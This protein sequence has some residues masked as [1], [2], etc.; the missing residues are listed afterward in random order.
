MSFYAPFV[1]QVLRDRAFYRQ[2]S[3][4]LSPL[5]LLEMNSN[6]T[7]SGLFVVKGRPLVGKCT[8]VRSSTNDAGH[9]RWHS[10]VFGLMGRRK[11]KSQNV[12]E[13]RKCHKSYTMEREEG[14]Q[15]GWNRERIDATDRGERM[16]WER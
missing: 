8:V 11:C 12:V 1:V 7:S 9:E 13:V 5:R 3:C 2:P 15:R 14:K 6:T 4:P 10:G 16:V